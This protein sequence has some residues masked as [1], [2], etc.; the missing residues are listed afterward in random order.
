MGGSRLL[1]HVSPVLRTLAPLAVGVAVVAGCGPRTAEMA[2]VS[3]EPRF[4]HLAYPRFV[5]ERLR[6]EPL[7]PLPPVAAG[8]RPIVFVHL[9]D[10][11]GDVVR[12]FD[13]ELPGGWREGEAFEYDLELFQSAIA[14]ALPAG[15]YRL[16]VGLLLADDRRGR[17]RVI[18]GDEVARREY[19]I[20]AV[21]VPPGD[22][23]LPMFRFSSA[24]Q[25]VEPSGDVQFPARRWF[26]GEATLEVAEVAGSGTIYLVLQIVGESA[27]Y[28]LR[29][30]AGAVEPALW[31]TSSCSDRQVRLAGAGRHEVLLPL[32][33]S[34]PC[35]VR[36]AP[37]FRLEPRAPGLEPRSALLE[38]IS[39]SAA[40]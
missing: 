3:A 28:G 27:D 15:E 30:E 12:T 7:A 18:G 6:W 35:D 39:W 32:S 13:H 22:E 5:V 10:R 29:L 8:G 36:L 25:P 40:P 2:A 37:N 31:V 34:A 21:D 26:D 17:L 33:A 38:A 24:F 4:V 14:P 19:R 11:E 23:A 20:A 1:R 16:S 9:L